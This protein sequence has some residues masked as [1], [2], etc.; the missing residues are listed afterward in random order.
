MPTNQTFTARTGKYRFRIKPSTAT[1]LF[2]CLF[3]LSTAAQLAQPAN[4]VKVEVHSIQGY[5][6]HDAFAR[7]AAAR[8]EKVINSSEFHQR[9]R[10][11]GY[12]Q[13]QGL[14]PDDILQ[15]IQGA[16]EVLGPGGTDGVVDLRLRTM[17]LE[18]DGAKWMGNCEPDSPARTIGKDGGSSGITVTCPQR[19]ESWAAKN[20]VARL[21]GHFMH[22]YMHQ[23]GFSHRVLGKYRSAVYRIGNMAESVA[24]T[25]D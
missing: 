17:T 14:T 16:H 18:E 1:V 10:S 13:R 20:D 5:G 22:E 9:V 21:V 8:L 3:S 19:I 4:P 23:L 6:Q 11:G 15:R 2:S 25:L 12:G 7:A 24:G